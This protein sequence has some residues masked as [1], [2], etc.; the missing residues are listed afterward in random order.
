[1]G[2]NTTP[3][4]STG[5]QTSFTISLHGITGIAGLGVF[6]RLV[7]FIQSEQSD[8]AHQKNH[9]CI[10]WFGQVLILTWCNESRW[11]HIRTPDKCV[12]FHMFHCSIWRTRYYSPQ[13]IRKI[14]QNLGKKNLEADSVCSWKPSYIQLQQGFLKNLPY[15]PYDLLLQTYAGIYLA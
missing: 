2:E 7:F 10:L 5:L 6:P 13:D 1:M 4:P 14:L 9:S 3:N 11:A 15:L 12:P 8:D